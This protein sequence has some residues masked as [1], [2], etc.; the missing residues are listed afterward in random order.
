MQ[1]MLLIYSSQG[2]RPAMTDAEISE[3]M[4]G[5]RSLIADLRA[6]GKYL[7][8]DALEQISAATTVRVR[9]GKTMTVDGP[10]AETKELLGGY[11]VVEARD[12]DDA[13]SIAA[14][15]PTAKTG[16]VEIRPIN[17]NLRM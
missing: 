15:I 12:L 6:T 5:Y 9:N 11:F 16:S 3:M 10:F 14:R 4:E 13:I 7:H 17:V 1:Y 8:S 2:G